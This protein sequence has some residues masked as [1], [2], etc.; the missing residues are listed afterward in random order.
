MGIAASE[1]TSALPLQAGLVR[2]PSNIGLTALAGVQPPAAGPRQMRQ[3][4][5]KSWDG[6][7][8]STRNG[9]GQSMVKP[10]PFTSALETAGVVPKAAGAQGASCEQTRIDTPTP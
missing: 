7:S 5:I 8:G 2:F 10:S 9:A 4:P 1:R 3:V 6:S